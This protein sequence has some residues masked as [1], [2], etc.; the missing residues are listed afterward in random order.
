M[1]C[2][3]GTGREPW[4]RAFSKASHCA[5]GEYG[6]ILEKVMMMSMLEMT[7]KVLLKHVICSVAMLTELILIRTFLNLLRQC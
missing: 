6:G 2:R 7:H 1:Y 4:G 5:N 3:A